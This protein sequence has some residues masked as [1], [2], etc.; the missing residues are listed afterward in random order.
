MNI[1]FLNMTIDVL[2]NVEFLGTLN[3][4]G[5]QQTLQGQCVLLNIKE[6]CVPSI[7]CGKIHAPISISNYNDGLF[8][9]QGIMTCHIQTQSLSFLVKHS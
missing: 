6:A 2:Q 1:L 3:F 9:T 7:V 4:G 8:N 5:Y